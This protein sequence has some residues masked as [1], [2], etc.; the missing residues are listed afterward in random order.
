MLEPRIR[1]LNQLEP[2]SDGEYVLYWMRWNRRAESN[3]ALAYAAA[4][5]NR[6]KLPLHL[7]I[8]LLSE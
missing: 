6:L 2:R 7:L 5:S 4:L 1:K 3:H 8:G